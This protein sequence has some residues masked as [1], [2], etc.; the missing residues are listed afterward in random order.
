MRRN[1]IKLE[2]SAVYHCISRTVAGELMLDGEAK[3]V[4][5]RMLWTV[6]D[7]S[8]VEVLAYCLMSNHFH[9]LV[10][11]PEGEKIPTTELLRRYTV[12]YRQ[13]T[14]PDHPDPQIMK[15][16]LENGGA[17]AER[18]R[19]RLERRMGDVSEFI[20]TLKQRFS[21]WYN[22]RH[23]RFGTLW[24]ERFKSVLVENSRFALQTV[25]AY[26][27][28]N[29]VRAHLVVDPAEYR[30]CSYA[31]ALAGKTEAR[32]GLVAVV[33]ASAGDGQGAL[34]SYRVTLFA[35]GAQ[36]RNA[37]DGVVDAAV[38]ERIRAEHGRIS[39]ADLRRHR[40]GYF[41][42]GAVIGSESFVRRVGETLGLRSAPRTGSL[43]SQE[44]RRLGKIP[45]AGDALVAWRRVRNSGLEAVE[46]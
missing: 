7:F 46:A 23:R 4:F 28:L 13:N 37:G 31:E 45:I 30:W 25:A 32:N 8:G 20:K 42:D 6:A 10:R 43:S 5:R 3:E 34:E 14:S 44:E 18:W 19:G 22:K 2:G 33:D 12:L 35:K 39:H 9:V 36:A 11:T 1:R 29:P 38:G 26:I 15:V 27:D 40:I 41:T 24:S 16:I 17:D 21:V